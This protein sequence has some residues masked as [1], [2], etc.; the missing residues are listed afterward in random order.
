MKTF[1]L[2]A[3]A[4]LLPFLAFTQNETEE[5]I[6]AEDLIA[7]QL[8][9]DSI[10][11]SLN[12]EH[13]SI[14]LPGANAHI[15]VPEGFGYLNPEQAN[16]VLSDLWGNPPGESLGLLV[17][18]GVGVLGD[19]SWAMELT[20]DEMGYVEDDDASD[21]DYT[22]LLG[23]MQKDIEAENE[24]RKAQGYPTVQLLGWASPPYYDAANHVLH[25]AKQ[26]KF[27]G[28]D[29]NGLNYNIRI[30]GRKGVMV[31][32]A[33]GRESQLGV[34][35][36]NVDK[37]MHSVAF[38]EG[39]TYADFDSGVDEVAA[40]T[41]GG[42]VAGKVLAK[43]GLFALFAKFGKIIILAVAAAGGAVWRFIRG[44]KKK[45]EETESLPAVTGS[46]EV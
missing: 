12:Y 42:L 1:S 36:A 45:E 9:I 30:L 26:V 13:G 16:Y 8:Q 24:Q 21:M 37:V 29:E 15:Q 46:E 25:W 44:R 5:E 38:N 18:D 33:I 10:E 39:Y 32:N 41:I 35:Q 40:Y 28:T 14:D 20:W 34:V 19:E 4:I 2:L 11:K 23:E 31:V 3:W 27:E 43:A 17:P 22:E 6:N 7:L